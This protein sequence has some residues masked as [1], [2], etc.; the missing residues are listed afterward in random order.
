DAL[1][2][3]DDDVA[4]VNVEVFDAEGRLVARAKDTTPLR[5]VTVGSQMAV[6]GS[7]QLRPHVRRGLIAVGVAQA[8]AAS[9]REMFTRPEVAWVASGQPLE[10]TRAARER[11]LGKAGYGAPKA[12]QTG[13]LQL[14]RRATIPVDLDGGPCAR[15]DVVAGAPLALVDAAVWDD[16]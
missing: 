3:P 16:S 12:T 7:L 9:A 13:Q 15:V 5:S 2:V 11:D 8:K 14:G 1:V 6:A 4:V 10:T